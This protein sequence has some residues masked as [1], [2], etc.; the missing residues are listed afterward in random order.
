MCDLIL[1]DKIERILIFGCSGS[2]KSTLAARLGDITGYT[3]THLDTSSSGLR[4]GFR[5]H[6]NSI[7]M[8]WNFNK[9]IRPEILKTMENSGKALCSERQRKLTHF[10]IA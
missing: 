9:D 10:R 2:G 6:V 4:V 7:K 5:L 3:V 8:M 1:P